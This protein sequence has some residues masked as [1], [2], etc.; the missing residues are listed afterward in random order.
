MPWMI[1]FTG[2]LHLRAEPYCIIAMR[3]YPCVTARD[4]TVTF[5]IRKGYM[6]MKIKARDL[7]SHNGAA[8]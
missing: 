8:S 7:A 4:A 5:V 2:R 1:G 6:S 3:D